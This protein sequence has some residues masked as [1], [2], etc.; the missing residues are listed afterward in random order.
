MNRYPTA[1]ELGE[2]ALRIIKA[3]TMTPLERFEFLIQKGIIDRNGRV[4]VNRLFGATKPESPGPN[5]AAA[6][7][8][9]NDEQNK[10]PATNS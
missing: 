10:K 1:R 9:V 8:T 2:E 6:D 5:G 3:D 4:L 7:P